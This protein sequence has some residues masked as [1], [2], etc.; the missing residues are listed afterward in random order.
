MS[1]GAAS[2]LPTYPTM[3]HMILVFRL[4][5][6]SEIPVAAGGCL[7]LFEYPLRRRGQI[8]HHGSGA[9]FVSRRAL[10]LRPVP[11]ADEQTLLHAGIPAA[12]QINQL[13]A[14]HIALR[15]VHAELIARIQQELR[16]R[17][18]AAAWRIGR[19]GR[20]VNLLEAHAFAAQ[21]PA[22][23]AGSLS[24]HPPA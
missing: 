5:V 7:G 11:G 4:R 12:F 24:R 14:N 15:Q 8:V 10:Q 2:F 21:V 20:D 16:R 13:V 23:D 9:Q 18:A 22:A 19:L 1:K 17:L 3:P 6:N